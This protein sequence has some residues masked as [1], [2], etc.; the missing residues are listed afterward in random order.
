MNE[1]AYR[2]FKMSASICIY[3]DSCYL[4]LRTINRLSIT[5]TNV[6]MA[7]FWDGVPCNLVEIGR[8]FRGAYCLHYQ[9][10]QQTV[11]EKPFHRGSPGS[12]PGQSNGI[13]SPEQ[14]LSRVRLR[15]PIGVIVPLHSIH[16][17]I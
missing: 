13:C 15:L 5:D 17:L 8:R 7:I 1:L 9:C 6:K 12:R 14:I 2:Y 10:D 16:S 11:R 4:I 3:F